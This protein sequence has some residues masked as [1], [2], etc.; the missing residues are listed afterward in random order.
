MTEINQWLPGEGTVGWSTEGYK[1]IKG[2]RDDY[3]GVDGFTGIY[4]CQ[5]SSSCIL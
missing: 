3:L 4:I 5:T 1:A 2:D